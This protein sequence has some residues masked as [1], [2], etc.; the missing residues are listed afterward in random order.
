MAWCQR[1][2]TERHH[3]LPSGNLSRFDACK[4]GKV[5]HWCGMQACSPYAESIIDD[6]GV[7]TATPHRRAVLCCSVHK[8]QGLCMK[9][10]FHAVTQGAVTQGVVGGT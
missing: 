4:D 10:A 6:V 3:G 1:W 9:L 8:G 5:V 7:Y 2:A